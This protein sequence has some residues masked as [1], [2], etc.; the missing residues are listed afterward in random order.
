[1]FTL[2]G[3]FKKFAGAGLFFLPRFKLTEQEKHTLS[4]FEGGLMEIRI[5]DPRKISNEQRAKIYAMLGDIDESVGNYLPEL[6]KK[7][8][9]RQFCADTLNEW[10]SLSDCSLELAKEFIDYLIQFCLAENIPWG[11]RTMDLIQGDYLLCYFGLKYRQ[12]CICRKH[13]Q[14]AHVH[15]VGSGRNRN[16]ISHVGN[17]VMPLC[18]YHHKE[19]H[20]IGIPYF[21]RKYQIKGVR[22]NQEIAEMLRLGDWRMNDDE[23]E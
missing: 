10:F 7:Q 16:K 9:K 13:A 3:Y 18:D 14:I 6:T 22:V 8:L 12:C 23:N 4:K 20:R 2:F 17:Y 1:M 19:Q 21:M 11:T 15:A 5:A